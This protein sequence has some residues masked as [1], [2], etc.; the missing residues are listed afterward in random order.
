MNQR[1]FKIITARRCGGREASDRCIQA[2][3][4]CW[5]GGSQGWEGG[6][7]IAT[8]EVISGRQQRVDLKSDKTGR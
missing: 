1:K 6:I 4:G 5:A 3:R 7:E 8:E 2:R